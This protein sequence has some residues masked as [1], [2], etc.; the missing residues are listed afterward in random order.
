[1]IVAYSLYFPEKLIHKFLHVGETVM[2]VAEDVVEKIVDATKDIFNTMVMIDLIP[3]EPFY[4]GEQQIRTDVMSLVSFTG[5]YN[6]TIAV[7]CPSNIALKIATNMLGMEAN[8]LDDDVKDAVGEVTNMIAGNVKTSLTES[9]GD[10]SLTIPLVI[11]GDGLSISAAG[12]DYEMVVVQS[13][14]CKS[15]DPWLLTPFKIVDDEFHVGIIFKK[16]A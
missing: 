16:V 2:Q 7:F 13:L 4:K 1:M 8:K 9:L 6:G 5:E 3:G 11:T 12:K 10:M 15:S 14:S